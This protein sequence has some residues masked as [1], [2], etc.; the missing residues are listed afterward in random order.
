MTPDISIAINDDAWAEI[1]DLDLIIKTAAIAAFEKA[2]KPDFLNTAY[3]EISFLMTNNLEIQALNKQYRGKDS[4]TN[5]LSFPQFDFETQN[6]LISFDDDPTPIGDIIM[7]FD[8]IKFEAAEQN[9]YLIAHIT[10]LVIHGVLHLLGYDHIDDDQAE[11]M[12]QLECEI[13]GVLEHPAPY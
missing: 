10:H 5:V 6:S 2:D 3:V 9:K 13:M 7:A 8:I 12:E 4:P 1:N 11:I